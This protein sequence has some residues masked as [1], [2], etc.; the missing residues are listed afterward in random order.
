MVFT[1]WHLGFR[2]L[3]LK[4][5]GNQKAVSG[6]GA[7]SPRLPHTKD[8]GGNCHGSRSARLE[9][10]GLTMD[11]SVLAVRLGGCRVYRVSGFRVSGPF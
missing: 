11:D 5:W 6:S 4:V 10:S 7:H 3:V 9:V 1:V 2:V 8:P